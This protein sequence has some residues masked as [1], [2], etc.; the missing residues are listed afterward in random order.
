MFTPQKESFTRRQSISGT[1][2]PSP[3]RQVVSHDT[4]PTGIDLG[5]VFTLIS[6]LQIDRERG[7]IFIASLGALVTIAIGA[8][9]VIAWHSHSEWLWVTFPG[10]FYMKY[11]TALGFLAAGAGLLA[12]VRRER[13]LT[14]AAAGVVVVIGG[15]TL[16]EYVA[17]AS[18]GFDE[19]FLKDYWYPD[20]PLRG[21]MAPS[22][23]IGLA[24]IGLMLIL[25][26]EERR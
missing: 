7:V 8:F 24:S 23:S 16:A 11:N 14:F 22:V 6:R 2:Q 4:I 10:M 15:I 21:R 13:A 25:R 18:L 9:G 3:K 17:G 20:N 19:L 5:R 26:S 12:C 1:H